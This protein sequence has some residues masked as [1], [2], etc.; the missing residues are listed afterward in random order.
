MAQSSLPNLRSPNPFKYVPLVESIIG[1]PQ[2]KAG[3]LISRY[4]GNI[5]TGLKNG[6]GGGFCRGGVYVSFAGLY[7]RFLSFRYPTDSP[8]MLTNERDQERNHMNLL[9]IYLVVTHSRRAGGPHSSV[10]PGSSA[11]SIH[12]RFIPL[13][14]R[15]GRCQAISFMPN[16]PRMV[17]GPLS[18]LLKREICAGDLRD[19]RR[20]MTPTPRSSQVQ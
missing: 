16:N 3:K 7:P 17:V 18:T 4:W 19:T 6:I 14:L 2:M 8:K 5:S 12:T 1:I 11:R 20:W 10:G 15:S 13:T 9:N